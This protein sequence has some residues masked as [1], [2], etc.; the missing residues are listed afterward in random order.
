MTG[1]TH[2]IIAVRL[3]PYLSC[4]EQVHV[5][6]PYRISIEDGSILFD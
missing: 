3:F 4:L 1:M 5:S 6:A 2:D